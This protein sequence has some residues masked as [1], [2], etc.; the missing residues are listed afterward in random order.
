MVIYI[1]E[2]QNCLQWLKRATG[3]LFWYKKT[4]MPKKKVFAARNLKGYL[5]NLPLKTGNAKKKIK[6]FFFDLSRQFCASLKPEYSN[7][8]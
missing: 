3:F 2:A 8:I 7:V 1:R 5:P 4:V 6:S